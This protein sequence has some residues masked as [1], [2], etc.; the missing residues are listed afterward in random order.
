MVPF[1]P[2]TKNECAVV[3]HKYMLKFATNIRQPIDLQPD[4]NRLMGHCRLSLIEDGDVCIS[5]TDKYYNQDLGARSLENAVK[6]IQH[7]F[8]E[9]YSDLNGAITED[10]NNGPLQCFTVSRISLAQDVYDVVVSAGGGV[11]TGGE[12]KDDLD[13]TLLYDDVEGGA[14][15]ASEPSSPPL[16]IW[17]LKK[18]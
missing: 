17:R 7:E 18:K 1:L 8:A 13:E 10:I 5:L 11:E 4:V 16:P 14:S 3:L 2:F 15:R 12:D 6:E 9:E